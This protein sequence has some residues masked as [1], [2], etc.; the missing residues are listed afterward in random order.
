MLSNKTMMTKR[1]RT[2]ALATPG[3]PE[4]KLATAGRN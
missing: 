2:V 4:S 1:K 3:K